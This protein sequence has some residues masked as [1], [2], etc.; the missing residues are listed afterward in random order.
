MLKVKVTY[1][2]ELTPHQFRLISAALRGELKEEWKDDAL[3]LQ[4]D[5]FTERNKQVQNQLGNIARL[6]EGDKHE[7]G[8]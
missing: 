7:T 6:S 1:Q 2:V 4:E 5:L 3:E 8:T